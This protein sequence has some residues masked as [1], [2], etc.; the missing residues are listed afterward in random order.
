[1]TFGNSFKAILEGIEI[2]ELLRPENKNYDCFAWRRQREGFIVWVREF[3][4]GS[5]WRTDII[6]E[7]N[8]RG[9]LCSYLI[10]EHLF[11]WQRNILLQRVWGVLLMSCPPLWVLTRCARD[12]ADCPP[13]LVPGNLSVPRR[14]LALLFPFHRHWDSEKLDITGKA[15]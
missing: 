12:C 13:V 9:R 11:T 5:R 14:R 8:S 4:L 1:M 3:A 10:P 7:N 2:R 15:G 6:A